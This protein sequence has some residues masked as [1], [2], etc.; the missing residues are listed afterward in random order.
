M[1]LAGQKGAMRRVTPDS[2]P[3]PTATSDGISSQ[4]PL[5]RTN[6]G[7]LGLV[8]LSV[9]LF[10]AGLVDGQGTSLSSAGTSSSNTG[11]NTVFGSRTASTM[12]ASASAIASRLPANPASNSS[13]FPLQLAQNQPANCSSIGRACPASAPC[14][15]DGWCDASAYFCG[16]NCE[17][18]NSFSIRSCYAR[19]PCFSYTDDFDSDKTRLINAADWDGDPL[20]AEWISMFQPDHAYL[21]NSRLILKVFRRPDLN[22]YGRPEG[23]G[24]SVATSRWMQ[25]GY[26]T[27]S[28]RTARGLGIVTA[29]IT[30]GSDGAPL[31]IEDE[32]D[33]E[34]V[35]VPFLSFLQI[36]PRFS[37]SFVR[38]AA[39]TSA[40]S[41]PTTLPTATSASNTAPPTI[42]QTTH[43]PLS[44][45]TGSP[46]SPTTSNGS[47][48]A[49]SSVPCTGTK[50]GMR[51][52]GVTSILRGRRGLLLVFGMGG[53]A[54]RGRR[55]G[56][57]RRRIGRWRRT[58]IIRW[59]LIGESR[60]GFEPVGRELRPR[61]TRLDG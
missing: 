32:I 4:R 18:L 29:F 5:S 11:T 30:R 24:A 49:V 35:Y 8:V 42:S 21:N 38:V 46:G 26:I 45:R 52:V 28:I 16:V 27:A 50:R 14:C 51:G 9:V 36:F 56:R 48:T 2:G 10:G 44:T 19:Y 41:T 54:R 58:R 53:W 17:P 34:A 25:Y 61:R 55:G 31:M 39:K 60:P 1:R 23:L 22:A 13:P 7:C 33:F 12:S 6:L 40:A 43:P 59:R 20:T 3:V 57:G 47:S 15:R 37:H